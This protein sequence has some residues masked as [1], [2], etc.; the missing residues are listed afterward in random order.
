MKSDLSSGKEGRTA[1]GLTQA[2]SFTKAR[3]NRRDQEPSR[4]E[5]HRRRERGGL[6]YQGPDA[7]SID[8]SHTGELRWGSKDRKRER[9]AAREAL[10]N[11]PTSRTDFVKPATQRSRVPQSIPYTTPASDFVYG[12]SAVTAALQSS[13]RKLY[14]LYVYEGEKRTNPARD[15]SIIKLALAAGVRVSK[16]G[17]DWMSLLDKMSKGRPHNVGSPSQISA[18]Y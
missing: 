1:R 4:D 5:G 11:D 12:T 8:R 7:N 2:S 14:R 6:L 18:H 16:V 3:D 10:R 15:L 17:E 9:S 13:R